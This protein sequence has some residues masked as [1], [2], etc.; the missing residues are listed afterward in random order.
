MPSPMIIDVEAVEKDAPTLPALT[1][2]APESPPP[3]PWPVIDPVLVLHAQ[4]RLLREQQRNLVEMLAR[5]EMPGPPGGAV[6]HTELLARSMAALDRSLGT[7]LGAIEHTF[8]DARPHR[9]EEPD[10]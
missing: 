8:A 1:E 4:R 9:S 10:R 6:P 3:G 5:I 2:P 7:I